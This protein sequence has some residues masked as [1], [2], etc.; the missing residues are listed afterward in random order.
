MLVT[1]KGK[2]MHFLLHIFMDFKT[3]ITAYIIIKNNKTKYLSK[4]AFFM[5]IENGIY[6][7]YL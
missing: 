2:I 5:F 4:D 3:H 6:H 1:L 7:F